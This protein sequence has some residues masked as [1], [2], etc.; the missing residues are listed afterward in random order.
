MLMADFSDLKFGGF[1]REIIAVIY[2]STQNQSQDSR[3]TIRFLQLSQY[4]AQEAVKYFE[5]RANVVHV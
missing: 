3:K 5:R 4:S 2:L 1:A